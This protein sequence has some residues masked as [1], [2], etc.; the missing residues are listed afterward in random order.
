MMQLG[1]SIALTMQQSGGGFSPALLFANGEQGVWFDP[2][3]RSTLFQ[4]AAGTTPVT[5]PAQPVGLM[6]DK[7]GNGRHATQAVAAQ[8]PTYQDTPGRLVLDKVDDRMAVTVPAGGWTGSMVLATTSGT[9]TYGV[10]IPAGDYVV[11][12]KGGFYFPGSALVGA[13]IRDGVLSPGEAAS[14]E[15]YMVGA[16]ATDSYGG[17]TNFSYFWRDHFEITSFPTIDTSSGTN[18]SQAWYNCSGLT[19]FPLIDTS[20]GTSFEF[21]WRGCSGLTSFPTINTS[22]STN[23][24][25]AWFVC[26]SLTSFPAG[27]FDTCPATNFEGAFTGCALTQASVDNILVSIN[28]AGKSGGTLNMNGGTSSPPSAT[29][30]A[31]KNSLIG[32]GWTVTTN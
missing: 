12:G 20:S 19:S 16:G 32:R 1:L 18:F 6:L 21:A 28:A 14:A 15:K 23:F 9:A 2:S 30:I 31:A 27:V 4:D 24:R 7:S 26:S 17:V 3:D 22:S 29:G 10:T 11:G 5:A 8:R 25:F 13:V